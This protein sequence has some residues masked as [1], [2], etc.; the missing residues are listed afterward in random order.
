M[1][2]GPGEWIV[3]LV[4][5]LL[6]F[7]ARKIPELARSLGQSTK[8][9]REGLE[10]GSAEGTKETEGAPE[11]TEATAKDTTTKDTTTNRDG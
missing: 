9:F 8:E 2:F 10:D 6:L 5:V 3:V 4:V 1:N 11:P 7:G